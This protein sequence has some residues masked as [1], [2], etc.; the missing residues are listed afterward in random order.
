MKKIVSL[1]LC[2]SMLFLLVAGCGGNTGNGSTS[3][4]TAEATPV[5]VSEVS[6]EVATEE[7]EATEVV[8]EEPVENV[9]VED[10]SETVE[11]E[12]SGTLYKLP[13][14]EE[15]VTISYFYKM[16][17]QNEI[18]EHNYDSYDDHPSIPVVEELTNVHID[19]Q[20]YN[21]DNETAL[22]ALQIASGDYCD[23]MWFRNYSG[24][25]ESAYEEDIIID[26]TDLVEEYAPNYMS[27]IRQDEDLY[28]S[29][30]SNGRYFT[31]DSFSEKFRQNKG[32]LIR[33]DWLDELGLDVPRTYDQLTDVLK[34]FHDAYNTT[35]TITMNNSLIVDGLAGGYNI[36]LVNNN[37]GYIQKDGVVEVSIMSEGFRSYIQMLADWYA[38]GILEEDFISLPNDPFSDHDSTVVGADMCGVWSAFYS[39]VD[40]WATYSSDEDFAA[41]PLTYP[42]VN[43][44]EKEHVSST[45]RTEQYI[46]TSITT[47]CD[48]PELALS[49]LDFWYSEIGSTIYTY[50]LEGVT[51]EYDE[52]G[53]PG[54]TDF[55][56]NNEYGV[57]YSKFLFGYRLY[58]QFGSYLKLNTCDEPY[59]TETAL[60]AWDTWT[61]S[62]DGAYAY[63]SGAKLTADEDAVVS[64]IANDVVTTMSETLIRFVIGERSMDEWDDFIEELKAMGLETCV[65]AYQAALDRYYSA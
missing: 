39:S 22:L 32:L 35:C 61:N 7:S 46:G 25:L 19:F 6:S 8:G 37:L 31:L 15:K 34:Q 52:N 3:A 33:Q 58:G 28:Y 23:L 63:P 55:V 16:F 2:L 56:L 54:F 62:L 4:E 14:T 29:V 50:G 11:T 49:W 48:C 20:T 40:N 38:E 30:T 27:Y 45:S 64:P 24:G 13:L 18:A 44:G 47:A 1:L 17:K 12:D 10:T 26:L 59:L 65:E 9:P 43:E 5:E 36:N 41:T 51:F 21:E 57:P 60:N 42:V 53:K